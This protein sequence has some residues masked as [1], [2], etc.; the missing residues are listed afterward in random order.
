MRFSS[1]L[2]AVKRCRILSVRRRSL[3][4]GIVSDGGGGWLVLLI[5]VWRG[6][7]LRLNDSGGGDEN[8]ID[9]NGIEVLTARGTIGRLRIV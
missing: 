6:C 1:P 4:S 8:S 5:S 3:R 2:T 7:S 9:S